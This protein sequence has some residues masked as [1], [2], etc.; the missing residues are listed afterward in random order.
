MLLKTQALPFLEVVES[1]N[2]YENKQ[3]I[4]ESWNVTD[5]QGVARRLQ[6]ELKFISLK[7]LALL[8]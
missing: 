2:V 7:L 3:D 1:W 8:A 6:P 4:R 5:K